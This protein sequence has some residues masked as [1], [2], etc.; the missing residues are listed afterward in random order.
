MQNK[1]RSRIKGK[2]KILISYEI[3]R[4][5]DEGLRESNSSV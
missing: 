2:N 4:D 3:R 5:G 1:K